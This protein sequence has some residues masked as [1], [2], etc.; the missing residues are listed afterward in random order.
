M[1]KM[2]KAEKSKRLTKGSTRKYM[3]GQAST[4]LLTFL[5]QHGMNELIIEIWQKKTHHDPCGWMIKPDKFQEVFKIFLT[6]K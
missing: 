2:S 3:D 4:L 1:L 6:V 5:T